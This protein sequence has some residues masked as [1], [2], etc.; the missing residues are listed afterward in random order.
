M[1]SS[2]ITMAEERLLLP[3]EEASSPLF[4][5]LS[6]GRFLKMGVI[7]NDGRRVS[8]FATSMESAA[9]PE[10]CIGF[11]ANAI[12]VALEKTG[13]STADIVAAGLSFPGAMNPKT[14]RLHRPPNHPTWADFPV[15]E[16]LVA[17]TG[18]KSVRFCNN[19]NAAAYGEYWIGEGKGAHSLCLMELD[20]GMGCGIIVEGRE[21]SGAHGYGGECGHM[22]LDPSPGARWCNCLQQGHLEAYVSATGL[23]RRTRELIEVGIPTVLASRVTPKTDLYDLPKMVYEEAVRGDRLAV[24]LVMD[25]A[26][27]LGIGLVSIL[28]TIDPEC[29][30]IGGDMMFGGKG[31]DLGERFLNRIREEIKSRVFR[32][33]ANDLKISFATLGSYASFIGAAGLA[34]EEA[35]MFTLTGE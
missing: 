19:A 4:L 24:D 28:H 26:K 16:R 15:C 3:L 22:I 17:A 25:T 18:L 14:N 2:P 31:S 13:L 23:A 32:E 27:F 10:L 8:Y 30:L 7:D 29:V 21:I 11:M 33:L 9:D 12:G 6:F 35:L 1:S 5:G 34:R 20:R